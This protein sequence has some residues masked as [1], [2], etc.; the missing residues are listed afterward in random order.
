M[1]ESLGQAWDRFKGLLRKTP[2][3]GFD[4]P[5]QLTL[6]L[7]G[8]KSQS[9]L[10]LDASAGGSIKWKTLEEAYEL[11]E[12][13]AANDNEVYTERAHSQKKG[14]LELQSQDALLAQNKIITQ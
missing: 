6:F 11:I 5:T 10:M 2:I 9:K 4:Q 1:D 7:A 14:I 8:L 3:H 13:M 12:N